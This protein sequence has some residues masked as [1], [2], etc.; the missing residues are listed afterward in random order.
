MCVCH[1]PNTSHNLG[2]LYLVR[3]LP[4]PKPSNVL[5]LLLVHAQ[6]VCVGG[7]GGGEG[8]TRGSLFKF[9][10]TITSL[11]LLEV[12]TWGYFYAKKLKL[13]I[14]FIKT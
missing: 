8:R 5:E 12:I 4:R 1:V 11:F 3:Y 7:G 13:D 2:T 14:L 6:S 9:T 10:L